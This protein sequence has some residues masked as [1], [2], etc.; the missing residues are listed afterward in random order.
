MKKKIVLLVASLMAAFTMSGC[1][2]GKMGVAYM[3]FPSEAQEAYA[4]MMAQLAE[5][6]DPAQAMMKEW[7][8]T[9]PELTE[10]DVFDEMKDLAAEYNM[11]YVGEKDMFRLLEAEQVAFEK[12]GIPRSEQIVHAKI[13][14]FCS[15]II[16]KKM[17][18]HSRFYGGFMPCRVAFVEYGDGRRY[19]IS[20]D[21]TLALYGGTDKKPISPEL[22]E[23]MQ[24][25]K[26]AMEEIPAIAA[27]YDIE[28]D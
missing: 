10:E 14:E 4:D 22:M 15:L 21:M 9:D 7:E 3:G 23:D 18:N 16:A 5:T 19:L 26:K 25:V 20:M 13:G 27:G 2:M 11:R 17:F 8:I 6:G 28:E 24:A 1:T 12:S